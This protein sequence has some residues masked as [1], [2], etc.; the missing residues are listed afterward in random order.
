MCG[1][2]GRGFRFTSRLKR[3]RPF[4]LAFPR[5]RYGVGI[6]LYGDAATVLIRSHLADRAVTPSTLLAL[7]LEI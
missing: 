2:F 7:G 5:D 6:A 3:Q 4:A 1:L